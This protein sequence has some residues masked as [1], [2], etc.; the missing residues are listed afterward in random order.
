ID[1]LKIPADKQ[2]IVEEAEREKKKVEKNYS[3]GLISAGER[4][5]RIID[6]W[7]TATN[8]I[9]RAVMD[10]IADTGSKKQFYVNPIYLMV[11]SGARGNRSQVNQLMGIR[12]L[13][14][15]PI[16]EVTGGIGEIIETPVI[17][18]FREGLDLLEYYIAIHGGRKGLVDTALKTS[19]AG[20]LSRKLV[21]VAHSVMVSEEDCSTLDGTFISSLMNGE[22]ELLSLK[23]RIIGRVA[24]DNVVD[25]VTDRIIVKAG[26]IIDEVKAQEIVDTGI[27]KIRIRSVLTCKSEKGVCAKCYGWDVSKKKIVN[28]GE[29][30]G[31]IAAQ[32]IGEPGTQLTLRTFHT[33]GAASRST[34]PSSLT[35][36]YSGVI[37]YPSSLRVV[38]NREGKNIVINREEN[39]LLNDERGREIERYPLRVGTILNVEDGQVISKDTEIAFWDPYAFPVIS[40]KEGQVVYKDIEVGNTAKEEYDPVVGIS[41]KVIIQ[42][43]EEMNPQ[44]ILKDKKGQIVGNYHL[45]EDAHIIVEEGDM[46]YPG[47][48][49]AKILRS[50]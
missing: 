2:K 37:K 45:P 10:T 11:S 8:K 25:I 19:E 5:N 15:R 36:K 23:E 17:S 38:R 21:D 43:K 3:K 32:S 9:G 6:I 31:V 7:T 34:G 44:I 33:G 4:Y 50:E 49:I 48:I 47:D 28:I 14:I 26:D 27:N 41:R 42:H 35:A 20:Y 22:E 1:D 18:N 30:V 46:I 29:A 13:M 12:G 40:E 39:I 16:R 24:V